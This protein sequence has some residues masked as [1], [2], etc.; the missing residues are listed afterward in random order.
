MNSVH[1]EVKE[2]TTQ[3]A[4]I[5]GEGS[6]LGNRAL[7]FHHQLN[8]DSQKQIKMKKLLSVRKASPQRGKN[9]SKFFEHAAKGSLVKTSS[10][11]RNINK[12]PGKA[13]ASAAEEDERR[14]R[15][16]SKKLK[17]RNGEDFK[18]AMA[19][20][21]LDELFEGITSGLSPVATLSNHRALQDD[22]E[23]DEEDDD[24]YED[25]DDEDEDEGEVRVEEE[26]KEEEEEE[27]RPVATA[28]AGK[29]IPPSKRRQL[30]EQTEN[31]AT[32]MA[33]AAASKINTFLRTKARGLLNKLSEHN[34][35]AVCN[36]IHKIYAD[37]PRGEVHQ[38]IILVSLSVACLAP[39]L[40][41]CTEALAEEL[42]ASLKSIKKIF[43]Q[44]CLE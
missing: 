22:D 9:R 38:G 12:R 27:E 3:E 44:V 39:A 16:L 28:G 8:T 42:A 15:M 1:D 20:D 6:E 21:G 14:I 4:F 30:E 25:N 17:I 40:S 41:L 35:Q 24:E 19:P 10:G 26:E 32:T 18:K 43:T 7:Y 36:D 2:C 29:Y 37:N 13:F 23:E 11:S 33:T 5:G 31:A 34:I